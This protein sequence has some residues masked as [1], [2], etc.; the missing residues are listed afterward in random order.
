MADLTTNINY[1]QPTGFKVVIDRAHFPNIA[2]F[3]TSV[4]HPSIS[5][6]AADV[7]FRRVNIRMAGDKLTFGE[8]QCNL[9]M[10]E[11][12]KAYQ[13]MYDWLES[14]V[15]TDFVSPVNR[16][17]TKRPTA[18]DITVQVLNS[19]N[20]PVKSIRYLDAIP[21]NLGDVQFEASQGNSFITFPV[22]FAFTYFELK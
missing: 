3:A 5:T 20:N 4:L 2:F 13:E 15:E 6:T 18:A 11:D 17:T 8:L 21:T 10:D 1:L 7:P 12:M 14:L 22:T 19:H 9:I 16:S